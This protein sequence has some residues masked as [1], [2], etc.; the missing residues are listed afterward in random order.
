[1]VRV[2]HSTHV[3]AAIREIG[4]NLPPMMSAAAKLLT[5]LAA[6]A[7]ITGGMAPAAAHNFTKLQKKIAAITNTTITSLLDHLLE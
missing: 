4:G 1:L 7:D 5:S 6:I 2:P 3:P